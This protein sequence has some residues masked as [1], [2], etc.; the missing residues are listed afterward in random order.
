[1]G[2]SFVDKIEVI[3]GEIKKRK[4]RW[5]LKAIPSMDFDD[6]SQ[7]LE[8]HIWKKW[9]LWD[10]SRPLEPWL[11]KVITHQIT[12]L[13]R[14]LYGNFA[15]PCLGCAANQGGDLCAI[16]GKQC[17]ECP[18]YAHWEKHKKNAHD[19]KLALPLV[20]AHEQE[21]FNMPEQS[22]DLVKQI[23]DLHVKMKR[24]LTPMQY[25]FY[26]LF[27]IK[28]YSEE[29]VAKMMGYKTNEKN[30][31]AGYKQLPNM[32]KTIISKAKKIIEV[33]L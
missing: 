29:E 15:R 27:Y 17:S 28:G 10:Q 13:I 26:D 19:V 7:I 4:G 22:T 1:M 12:N 14:N 9:E 2:F 11:N 23:S 21:V 30:R 5:K 18:I 25:K 16:Y 32:K 31:R 6:V 20:G 8:F 33:D 3:R 24:A